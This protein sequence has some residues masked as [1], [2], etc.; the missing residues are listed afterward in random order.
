VVVFRLKL[1]SIET[2]LA[3]LHRPG[4]RIV[5]LESGGSPIIASQPPRGAGE[6]AYGPF[7]LPEVGWQFVVLVEPDALAGGLWNWFLALAAL[8]LAATA[9]SIRLIQRG[10]AVPAPVA[11]LPPAEPPALAIEAGPA[12]A[13]GDLHAE[14]AHDEATP[15]P[16]AADEG[17]R[18]AIVEVMTRALDCWQKT[19]RKGK[20][21]LAE[22]SGLWRVYMDRSSLQTRTLDKYLLVE[23][24][25]RNPRWRDVVRTAEYVL[26]NAADPIPERDAL[27]QALAAL[28]HY[29]KQAERV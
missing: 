14:D 23:T 15:D 1:A 10:A 11:A 20:I 6:V 28:K 24:L 8:G 5:L 27:V 21:E 22:D 12:A 29:L 26:R 3:E 13:A 7:T 4:I 2:R 16:L 25:P 19:K 17:F 9:L 18:R